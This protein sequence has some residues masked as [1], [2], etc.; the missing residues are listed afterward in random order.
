MGVLHGRTSYSGEMDASMVGQ[1]IV[2][3]A[4]ATYKQWKIVKGYGNKDTYDK[5][6]SQFVKDNPG[7]TDIIDLIT[8]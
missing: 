8:Q 6:R 1:K 7:T 4:L 2:I 5:L 3:I